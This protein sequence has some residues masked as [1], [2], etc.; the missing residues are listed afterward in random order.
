L[1]II[2]RDTWVYRR[3]NDKAT[4]TFQ[5]HKCSPVSIPHSV[6]P[7]PS[8]AHLTQGNAKLAKVTLGGL[9]DILLD[10]PAIS[11]FILGFDPDKMQPIPMEAH[12]P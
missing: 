5:A 2:D 6:V 3:L 8:S 10:D 9:L 1:R 4:L 7:V 12:K 11:F